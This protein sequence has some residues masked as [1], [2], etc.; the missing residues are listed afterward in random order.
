MR[1]SLLVLAVICAGACS[2]T[3][4]VTTETKPLA[5]SQPFF[6]TLYSG[7][8]EPQRTVI[9]NEAAWSALWSQIASENGTSAPPRVDFSKEV[10]VVAAMGE[11][12]AAGYEIAI[13][14]VQRVLDVLIVDVASTAP[15]PTCD[16]SE[17]ITTPLQAVRI[18]RTDEAVS[19]HERSVVL[20]CS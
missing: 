9:N 17:V 3:N 10:V 15:G 20:S 5:V 7:V 12:K 4:I 19:F 14:G 16:R 6:S 2:G 13:T 18:P 8:R 11:R 1:Q